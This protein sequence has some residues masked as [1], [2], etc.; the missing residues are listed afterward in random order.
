MFDRPGRV[1]VRVRDPIGAGL[2]QQQIDIATRA[3]R[4]SRQQNGLIVGLF[5]NHFGAFAAANHLGLVGLR[6]QQTGEGNIQRHAQR[7][8]CF[9]LGLPLPDSSCDRVDLAIPA[10]RATSASESP[11]RERSRVRLFSNYADGL[12]HTPLL[13]FYIERIVRL[14][15][16]FCCVHY[17]GNSFDMAKAYALQIFLSQWGHH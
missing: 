10:R 12:C 8:Q 2:R 17:N 16:P 13:V 3:G 4:A 5:S 6:F 7:P 1:R 9:R 14:E 11:V 15:K